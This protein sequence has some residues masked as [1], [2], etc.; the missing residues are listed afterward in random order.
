MGITS[1][2]NLLQDQPSTFIPTTLIERDSVQPL[3]TEK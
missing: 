1:V 2:D 3:P